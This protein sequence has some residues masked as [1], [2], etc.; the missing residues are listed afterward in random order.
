MR[1]FCLL[2]IFFV[3][4]TPFAI[5]KQVK[6]KYEENQKVDLGALS[7]DG[8]VVAPGDISVSDEAS[9][10]TNSLFRRKD[11]KDKFKSSIQKAF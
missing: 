3:G 11:Y 10:E 8:E 7:V 1:L 2:L 6:I 5:S 4:Y 9:W